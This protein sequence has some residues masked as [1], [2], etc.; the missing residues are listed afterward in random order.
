MPDHTETGDGQ[1]LSRVSFREDQRALVALAC[2]GAVRIVE[3]GDACKLVALR[4]RLL[5][6]HGGL[7]ELAEVQSVVD[8]VALLDGLHHLLG[9]RAGGTK[10][11][12]LGGEVL[13]G[14]RIEGRV[15]DE[16][17]DDHRQEQRDN[18]V[19]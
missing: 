7:L 13:L 4:A 18:V 15:H 5:H 9:D 2:A 17:V 10:H 19:A 6:P 1:G 3:L 8:D 14:L 12:L 11:L 16:G